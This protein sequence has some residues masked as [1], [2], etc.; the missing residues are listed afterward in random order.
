M[1]LSLSARDLL[2]I[3]RLD[4]EFRP[5]L[6]ALTGE[7]GA[8]KSILLDALGLALGSR[9]ESGLIRPAA[10]RA[11]VTAE[12]ELSGG[13][14]ALGLAHAQGLDVE[15]TLVL[16]RILTRDGKS[17]A[18]LNDQPVSAGLLRDIG[19]MLVEIQGQND[20]RGLLDPAAHRGFLDDYAGAAPAADVVALAWDTWSAATAALTA[21]EAEAARAAADEEYL[22]HVLGELDALD[23]EAGEE[24]ELATDRARLRG[25]EQVGDALA[26]AYEALSGDGGPAARMASAERALTR[27]AVDVAERLAPV[28]EALGRAAAETAEAEAALAAAARDLAPDPA[29]L[30]RVE[31]RLFALRGAARK[32]KVEADALPRLREEFAGRLRG[33]ESG[34]ERL[35]KLRAEMDAAREA[36]GDATTKLTA[37]RARAAKKLD[38]AVSGELGP[39]RMHK[40]LFRTVISPLEESGWGRGGADRI[41]FEVQTNPGHEAGLLHRVASGGELG[42]FLLALRV[43]LSQARPAPVLIFDEVDRGIGGATAD[44]VGERLAELGRD[45]QVLVVTHSPQVAARADSHWRIEKHDSEGTAVTR[46]TALDEQARREEVARML[47][48]ATVTDEARAAAERLM[49]GADAE[50]AA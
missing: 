36:Y 2:L 15:G 17:R 20:G 41:R 11:Q 34:A 45:G 40:A 13:H 22:R 18:T 47:A 19:G 33:I 50:P 12:F 6:C 26:A 9:A 29:R 37:I 10:E 3:D 46:V 43:V 48:G 7:T 28:L 31:E 24:A 27:G 39:L 30:E 25:A 21:A 8:G 5:G 14:P 42:R 4:V 49:A 16:R 1:L 38:E 35:A 23:A 32:H 44:A